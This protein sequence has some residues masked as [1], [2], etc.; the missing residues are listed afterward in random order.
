MY[1]DNVL[2]RKIQNN[3]K[4]LKQNK[5][6]EIKRVSTNAYSL[7]VGSLRERVHIT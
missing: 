7:R 5:N 3:I 1:R 6:L 4:L 2:L